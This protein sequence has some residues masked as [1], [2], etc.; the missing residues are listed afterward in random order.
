MRNGFIIGQR[1]RIDRRATHLL[2]VGCLLSLLVGSARSARASPASGHL[3]VSQQVTLLADGSRG[4]VIANL[5][6]QV[7][8]VASVKGAIPKGEFIAVTTGRRLLAT[9][10][11]SPCTGADSR[12]RPAD[13]VTYEARLYTRGK[14]LGPPVQIQVTWKKLT[15]TLS[16]QSVEPG[17][18]QPVGSNPN[19]F[20]QLAGEI[21][22]ASCR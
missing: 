20:S 15:V 21:G 17:T 22:R 16:V 1:N 7:M 19:Q 6:E 5:D 18:L 8:F 12:A 9:C 3:A 4:P 10:S 13:A 11:G 2:L 14:W